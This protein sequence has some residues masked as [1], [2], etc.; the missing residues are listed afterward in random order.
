MGLIYLVY[1]SRYAIVKYDGC[2]SVHDSDWLNYFLMSF[3]SLGWSLA[4]VVVSILTLYEYYKRRF[5]AND[6][7]RSSNSGT[8]MSR[9]WRTLALCL[10]CCIAQI[11]MTVV[12]IITNNYEA[13]PD[14]DFRE[15]HSSRWWDT[16]IYYN[17]SQP[18]YTRWI[19]VAASFLASILL[20]VGENIKLFYISILR[21][22]GFDGVI[23][24]Y[25]QHQEKKVIRS[26]EA[27]DNEVF[28]NSNGAQN[29]NELI[30]TRGN[31]FDYDEE[32]N[33]CE[34]FDENLGRSSAS[35]IETGKNIRKNSIS[36]DVSEFSSISSISDKAQAKRSEHAGL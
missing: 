14:Y 2:T 31:L 12:Y 26:L 18:Y 11:P 36:T 23:N 35:G 15:I 3:F 32:K 34:S 20:G 28:C 24:I 33:I 17:H 25:T 10:I 6:L 30:F 13:S 8:S 9:I 4:T 29:P 1:M 21:R 16:I 27:D 22:L 5:D 7:V 19:Y